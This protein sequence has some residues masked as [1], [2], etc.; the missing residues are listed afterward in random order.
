MSRLPDK[1][2]EGFLMI[3]AYLAAI[4]AAVLWGA[5]FLLTKIVLTQL[6]PMSTAALRWAVAALALIIISAASARGREVLRRALRQDVWSFVGLGLVGV[7][8]FYAL[9]NLALVYTTSIDVGLIM[10]G[11]PVLTVVLGV[12]LLGEQLPRRALGGVVVALLGVTL[13]TLGGLTE[14]DVAAR[15]RIVGGLLAVV[16][17][18]LGAGYI[19]GGKRT[20]VTYDPLTVTALAAMFGALM[21]VPVA[22]WEGLT[23]PLSAG[24]WVAFLGLALGSG[25]AANWLWWSAVNRLPIAR[26]GVFLYITPVVSTILGV[27]VLDEPLTITTVVGAAFVLGGVML[28]QT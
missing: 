17:T 16:A 14:I 15:A 1:S 10:N 23:L 19:V 2:I 18:L 28:V 8:L 25:A 20:V 4:C 7:S 11:V 6:G 13:I 21:L 5:S 3:V 26:A 9:Q 22:A 12:R 27:A 24:V